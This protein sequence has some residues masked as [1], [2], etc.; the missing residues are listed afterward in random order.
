[1]IAW[2]ARGWTGDLLDYQ[3]RERLLVRRDVVWDGG[4]VR[5]NGIDRE[6]LR[7]LRVLG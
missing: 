6:W 1:M 2:T 7:K 4:E 3:A 5:F